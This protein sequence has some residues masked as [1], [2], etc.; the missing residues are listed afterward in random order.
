MTDFS[1]ISDYEFELLAADVVGKLTGV[2]LSCYAPGPD[3]G[4]DASNSTVFHSADKAVVAQAKHYVKTDPRVLVSDAKKLVKRLK[5]GGESPD[6]LYFVTSRELTRKRIG[7]ITAILQSICADSHVVHGGELDAILSEEEYAGIL[8][9]YPGL[10]L[11]KY[12]V[13]HDLLARECVID[14]EALLEEI[15]GRRRLYK[16]TSAF[17]KALEICESHGVCLVVGPPGI[18]KT[19]L[20][21]LLVSHYAERGFRVRYSADNRVRTIKRALS[22]NPDVPEVCL[23][24][25]FLGQRYYNMEESRPSEV[26][27]LVRYVQRL[28]R[29]GCHK[30]ILVLNSRVTVLN[31]ATRCD[32]SFNTWLEELGVGSTL[33]L[34]ASKLTRRD[35][36][37]LLVSHM[38]EAG[39]N[40]AY[41]TAL[42]EDK[43]YRRIIDSEYYNPRVVERLCKMAADKEVEP[44]RFVPELAESLTRPIMV[45]KDEY[46]NRLNANDRTA[47]NVL[48]SLTDRGIK[49]D[50]LK[51]CYELRAEGVPAIDPSVSS[52]EACIDRLSDSM[53]RIFAGNARYVSAANPSINDFLEQALLENPNE[54]CALLKS[55]AYAEQVARLGSL[56]KVGRAAEI[57]ID[58]LEGGGLLRMRSL[59]G[60]RGTCYLKLARRYGW[61]HCG[62]G[63]VIIAAGECARRGDEVAL[64]VD[65]LRAM[66]AE[67]GFAFDVDAVRRGI[68]AND[69]VRERIAGLVR[70]DAFYMLDASRECFPGDV[71]GFRA[72]LAEWVTGYLDNEAMDIA[73]DACESVSGG[74]TDV[75]DDG[76]RGVLEG[77][78]AAAVDEAKRLTRERLANELE[79]LLEYEG[80]L[81]EWLSFDADEF[82]AGYDEQC[83]YEDYIMQHE[84]DRRPFS[85]GVREV[86]FPDEEIER[87]LMVS[88]R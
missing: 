68:L 25:D 42:I 35:R 43:S 29:P 54:I 41:A 64:I 24:D 70:D 49:A 2:R 37:E 8:R 32:P 47:L 59:R 20:S 63:D 7:E 85:R 55:A 18:G 3:G 60:D 61:G 74:C 78:M 53:L 56:P 48:F 75:D 19:C 13:L 31:E 73:W 10:W 33:L 62:S 17:E 84:D 66:E 45:W 81:C 38:V 9:R 88:M 30:K 76:N 79:D 28:D 72:I 21:H 11:P 46:E 39:V 1:A 27:S 34:D 87:M 58:Y 23:M 22:D 65:L 12:S 80:S 6:T 82:M 83:D 52:F 50:V 4:V 16:A 36:A 77:P 57:V 15:E 51:E 26:A 5:E 71:R 69:H 44:S 14:G 86:G 67:E 40:A